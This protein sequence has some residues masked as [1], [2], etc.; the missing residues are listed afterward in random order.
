MINSSGFVDLKNTLR[1]S[2]PQ[3][4]IYFSGEEGYFP[5]YRSHLNLVKVLQQIHGYERDAY[6]ALL[7][8]IECFLKDIYCI[9]RYFKFVSHNHK[10]PGTHISWL[11]DNYPLSTAKNLN[12]KHRFGHG[13]YDLSKTLQYDVLDLVNDLEFDLFRQNLPKKGNWIE[14][15][16]RD[17]SQQIK[18]NFGSELST[19]IQLFTDVQKKFFGGLI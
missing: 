16:Y 2:L 11:V 8:S 4:G 3:T 19:M 17:P 6:Y 15:R 12:P 1:Q 7:I 9:S 10:Q 13:I 18:R 5:A 14:D